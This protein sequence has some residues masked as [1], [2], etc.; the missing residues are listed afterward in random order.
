MFG[1][2]V[3]TLCPPSDRVKRSRRRERT[4]DTGL[5]WR[6][7]GRYGGVG[8]HEW[9][10]T[11]AGSSRPPVVFVHG[12]GRDASDWTDHADALLRAGYSGDEL[13]AITFAHPHPTH[14]EMAKQLDG[15]VRQVRRYT[16]SDTV[17]VVAH[18]L[19]VTGV[20]YWMDLR[21]RY[22][23]VESFVAIAGAN[24]GVSLCSGSEDPSLLGEY[25]RPSRFVGYR[26]RDDPN[27]PLS[28]LNDGDETPGD[29]AYYTIRGAYDHYYW[30]DPNS[31]KLDGAVENV[32]LWTNHIGTLTSSE[33]HSLVV[34]WLSGDDVPTRTAR[35]VAASD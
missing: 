3:K 18:S 21:G 34:K 20:R 27:H 22:D 4:D 2:A 1:H 30:H 11:G 31:P 29:V 13:W 35:S 7:Y 33:T 25:S 19:G 14:G 6:T 23:W 24:H 8:G 16:G 15:F 10:E 28:R 5:Q 17:S 26:Y 32:L 9:F 12:N